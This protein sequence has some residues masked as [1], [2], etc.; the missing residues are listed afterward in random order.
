M[1]RDACLLHQQRPPHLSLDSLQIFRKESRVE[2]NRGGGRMGDLQCTWP[3]KMED[4]HHFSVVQSMRHIKV[5][6][7]CRL[8]PSPPCVPFRT[9]TPS[10]SPIPSP[11]CVSIN[12]VKRAEKSSVVHCAAVAK[13]YHA[14]RPCVKEWADFFLLHASRVARTHVAS[15]RLSFSNQETSLA[16]ACA[17]KRQTKVLKAQW[18]RQ[19]F[20]KG[21]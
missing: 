9:S 7:H 11:I 3:R 8:S 15:Y 5:G 19:G 6:C 10:L 2:K 16:A 20:P 17:C 21:L 18:P 1:L 4:E 12:F 13:N 14:R